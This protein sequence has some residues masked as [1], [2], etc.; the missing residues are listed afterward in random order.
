MSGKEIKNVVTSVLAR[1][2]NHSKSSG[3]PFQ[4]VLQQYAIERLLY[5]ISKS[6]HAQ[7]VILK[8]ALL[9]KTIGI[10]SS[11]PTMDIDM[12]RKG[13]ADQVSL[14]ALVKDCASLETETDGLTFLADSVLAEE[15]TKDSEYKGT[16]ILM[17]A[18]MGNGS[19]RRR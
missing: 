12:L 4:Q 9:L 10:P 1:L 6:K 18:R 8:G 15:I 13:K 19:A 14:V 3:A 7:T 2:R 17:D 5:R 16:R 11:R